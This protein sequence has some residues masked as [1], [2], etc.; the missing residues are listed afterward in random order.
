MTVDNTKPA[1]TNITLNNSATSGTAAAG[2][3]VVITYSEGLD[4]DTL[5]TTWT[6]PGD[7]TTTATVSISTSD[8]LTVGSPCANL[9]SIALGGNYN[10]GASTRTF[11]SSTIAWN[12]SAH[13][14]TIT[15][16]TP[17]GGTAGTGVSAAVP[18]YTPTT[19]ISDPAGNTMNATAVN[20]T[21]SRF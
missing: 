3:Y 10:T 11:S 2:D 1:P 12:E 18:V 21:S 16:G 5:C 6:G 4:P 13:T 20:G 15:L 8:A 17:S 19:S 14:I 9:G 7:Q